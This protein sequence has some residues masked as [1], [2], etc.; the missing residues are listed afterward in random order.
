MDGAK[1]PTHEVM[2]MIILWNKED[3]GERRPCRI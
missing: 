3:L 2:D 1:N